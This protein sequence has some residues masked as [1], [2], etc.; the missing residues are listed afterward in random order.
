MGTMKCFSQEKWLVMWL[1]TAMNDHCLQDEFTLLI[2][3]DR[4]YFSLKLYNFRLDEHAKD[5][6]FQYKYMSRYRI[7]CR[8]RHNFMWSLLSFLMITLILG[9]IF[10]SR[11]MFNYLPPFHTRWI[12][13][14]TYVH[15]SI[16]SVS[17]HP[18]I[19]PSVQP[20]VC[21]SVQTWFS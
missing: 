2:K 16:H 19:H 6:M 8:N 21:L 10:G 1:I 4:T 18:S 14:L 5:T 20:S 11:T 7:P 15:M 13:T 12:F 3:L 9:I 17:V